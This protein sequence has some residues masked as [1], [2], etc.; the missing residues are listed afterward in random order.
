M[1]SIDDLLKEIDDGIKQGSIDPCQPIKGVQTQE[2][3]SEDGRPESQGVV[4]QQLGESL[5]QAYHNV[6]AAMNINTG[7]FTDLAMS[8]ISDVPAM[9]SFMHMMIGMGYF[10]ATK[11]DLAI[12]NFDVA[13]RHIE[14][15]ILE[16]RLLNYVDGS[17][18]YFRGLCYW[19]KLP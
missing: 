11:W 19:F 18:Y 13:I 12:E 3:P 14:H 9:Q 5:R 1:L 6:Y 7:N 2:R 8:L 4:N 16:H 15:N 17:A 10:M